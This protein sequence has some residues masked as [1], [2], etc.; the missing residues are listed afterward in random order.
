[1][2]VFKCYEN[3]GFQSLEMQSIS[4]VSG[5]YVSRSPKTQVNS[6]QSELRKPGVFYV[7]V[8]FVIE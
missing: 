3:Q 2:V 7:F 6:E 1:L 5:N 8:G 4:Y